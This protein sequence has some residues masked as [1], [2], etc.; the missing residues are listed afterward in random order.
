MGKNIVKEL[1][2]KLRWKWHRDITE[3]VNEQYGLVRQKLLEDAAFSDSILSNSKR[4]QQQIAE[5][6]HDLSQTRGEISQ[7]KDELSQIKGSQSKL[8]IRGQAWAGLEAFTKRVEAEKVFSLLQD[9]ES[10]KLFWARLHYSQS[11]DLVPLTRYLM[12]ADRPG[13]PR[14]IISMLRDRL[15]GSGSGEEII[16]FGTTFLAKELFLTVR[17]LGLKVDFICKGDNHEWY[18]VGHLPPLLDFDW[19]GVPVISEEALL[20]EHSNAQLLIGDYFDFRAPGVLI[21][22]GFPAEQIWLRCTMWEK[23]YLDP[24][25]IQPH[26][27][28]IYVDGGVLNLGNTLEFIDWCHDKYDAVYAFEPDIGSYMECVK[29]IQ[30]VPELDENRVHLMHAA[31]WKCDEELKFQG[32]C[33]GVSSVNA[34]GT[35][36][37]SGRSLDTVLNGRRIT[38]LKLDI[39]GAE[40]AALMGAK[41]TIKK[42][43]PRLAISIYHRPEDPIDIP[44]YIH[45]LVPEY[46]MYIRHYSTC[47]YE[48]VLY[49]ICDSE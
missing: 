44:L 47:K 11:G 3:Q 24:D 42:W 37:V 39:E 36:A 43:K 14:D 12:Q 32:G 5:M 26:E 7:I 48:T 45:G 33:E 30:E 9:R 41:E 35:S 38:F 34:C 1:L 17:A 28:E 25:I 10:Q 4:Q 16:I 23:Q 13:N 20:C 31:L 8:E 46:K 29:R 27:H 6:G 15:N 21:G 40:M 18:T 22:K 19:L 49:C 2:K